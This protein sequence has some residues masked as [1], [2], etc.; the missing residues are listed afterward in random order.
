MR[1]RLHA[2]SVAPHAYFAE[3]EEA[4]ATLSLVTKSGLDDWLS[5]QDEDTRDWVRS[6]GFAAEEHSYLRLPGRQPIFVVGI[7]E[8]VGKW[9][10]SDLPRKL[11]PGVYRLSLELDDVTAAQVFLG[12]ASG[13]YSFDRYRALSPACARLCWPAGA[14][15]SS[16]LRAAEAVGLVR[17]LVTLPAN[18]MGPEE[19]TAV[20]QTISER[21]G[22]SFRCVVGDDLLDANYPLI[23]AVGRASSRLPRLIDIQWGD[24]AA[25]KVTLVGKGV[26]F[27]AGGLD[28]KQPGQMLLMKKD[29]GGAAHVLALGQMIMDARLP[30]RLRVLVP[31]VENVVSANAVRPLDV[32]RAR[33]GVSVE[34]GNTDAEG[35]LI[36]ADA[37]TEACSDQPDLLID[38]A[39]L[40][41]AATVALG[42]DLPA[43]FTNDQALE[44]ALVAA[45]GRVEDPMWVLPLWAPYASK[46]KSK[47]AD[48]GNIDLAQGAGGGAIVAGLF[49]QHFVQPHVPWA[50][51][52]VFGWNT[53]A[54]PGRPQGGEAHGL[55]A[56]FDMLDTRFG[57]SHSMLR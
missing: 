54:R 9:S 8:R 41:G 18:D 26:C 5:R 50:H 22:A 44:S 30:V 25:P 34:I 1:K 16:I 4:T 55:L 13:A 23:H 53:E 28:L 12:W 19:L 20:A 45:G 2:D 42:Q 15:R 32:I 46:L 39:T 36:L 52:D 11:P 47:I 31:A 21:Y 40:T 43:L 48:L 35:R 3:P 14:D 38:F 10:L 49:L 29:M 33:S 56:A 57:A 24:P 7:G 27:D 6:S 51:L 37:I 17:D